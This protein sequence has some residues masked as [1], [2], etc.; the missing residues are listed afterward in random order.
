MTQRIIT[1]TVLIL[2]LAVFGHASAGTYKWVDKDGNVVYSQH[3]PPEGQ[4]ESIRVKPT[5][6]NSRSGN[7]ASEQSNRFL[8]NATTKRQNDAK[9]AKEN[10]NNLALRQKN[11]GIAKEQLR[12][13]TVY[14]RKKNDKG[15]YVRI[16]DDE[17]AAGL[18]EAKQAIK[19]FCD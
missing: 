12:F 3:P 1:N 18:K 4:F 13:Y 19:D 17:K 11:C 16:T 8:E 15:E 10:K 5:P 6:R 7:S 2:L 9:L 14:R